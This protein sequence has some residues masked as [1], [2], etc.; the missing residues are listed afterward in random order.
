MSR[1]LPVGALVTLDGFGRGTI[2]WKTQPHGSG[3]PR[4]AATR[5]E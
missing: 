3:V 2:D 1:G 5:F 4:V